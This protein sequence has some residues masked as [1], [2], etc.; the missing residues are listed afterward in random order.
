MTFGLMWGIVHA[1]NK[2]FGLGYES[3]LEDL[4]NA[5]AEY[6]ANKALNLTRAPH[7]KMERR[8]QLSASVGRTGRG[9]A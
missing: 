6:P 1:V 4:K 7:G 5:A 2:R 9:R 3:Q 8:S